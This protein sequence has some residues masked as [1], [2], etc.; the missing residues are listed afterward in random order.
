MISRPQSTKDD[1]RH[2]RLACELLTSTLGEVLDISASGMRVRQ[3]GRVHVVK[4]DEICITIQ[5]GSSKIPVKVRVAWTRRS[6]FWSHQIG[7]EFI[8][9]TDESRKVIT[10][11][12]R[13]A[14]KSRTIADTL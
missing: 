12:S 14:R 5:F 6:G 4:G 1:R 9:L 7:V 2:G 11:L 8:D 3:S 13:L 10:Q